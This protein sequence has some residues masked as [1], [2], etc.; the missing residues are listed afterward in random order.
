M[1]ECDISLVLNIDYDHVDYFKNEEDYIESFNK[2]SNKSKLSILNKDDLNINKLKVNHS[3]YFSLNDISDLILNKEGYSF[4]YKGININTNIYGKKNILNLI[5]V[6]T[7]FNYLNIDTNDYKDY[8]NKFNGVKRR[9]KEIIVNGDLY[10]D[11][12]AHHPTQILYTLEMI[13][14]KYSEYEIIV[15]FKPDRASRFLTFYKDFAA[16]FNNADKVILLKNKDIDISLLI[17]E[18]KKKFYKFNK[19][20]IRDVKNRKKKVVVSFSSKNMNSVFESIFIK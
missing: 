9:F 10:I 1:Y 7:L 5:G 4:K 17:K 14:N 12:Y 3:L 16:S 6:I 11:D 15:F 19:R 8:I 20:V 18:N 2:F 13:K